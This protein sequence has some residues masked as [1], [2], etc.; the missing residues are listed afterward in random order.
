MSCI[1]IKV[2]PYGVKG[3]F[4]MNLQGTWTITALQ[5]Q[6]HMLFSTPL[7][8]GAHSCTLRLRPVHHGLTHGSWSESL[9]E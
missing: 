1:L 9:N 5:L 3:A 7:S 6:S 2:I 4:V 8:R